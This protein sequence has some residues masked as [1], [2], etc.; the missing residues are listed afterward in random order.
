MKLHLAQKKVRRVLFI[1]IAAF[2][3]IGVTGGVYLAS[4]PRAY[5]A[6]Q[7]GPNGPKPG[8]CCYVGPTKVCNF[9]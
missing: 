6:V 5:A 1:L 7:C 4:A 8:E 9:Q 3:L 2:M